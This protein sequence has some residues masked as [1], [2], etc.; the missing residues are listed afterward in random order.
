[1]S[2]HPLYNSTGLQRN[3]RSHVL[4]A[5]ADKKMKLKRLEDKYSAKLL[6]LQSDIS[7]LETTICLFDGDCDKTITKIDEKVSKSKAKAVRNSYFEKGECKMLVLSML[8]ESGIPLDTSNISMLLAEKKALDLDKS[9]L[10]NLQ[11]TVLNTLGK[12][13]Q[14]GLI[15]K[16]GKNSNNFLWSIKEFDR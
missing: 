7:A 1:M 4:Y 3:N 14:S 13:E 12:C 10:T 16:V 5:L 6:K 9:S 11:K 15:S 2:R 8:R